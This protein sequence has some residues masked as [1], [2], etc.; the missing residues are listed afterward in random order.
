MAA[1]PRNR[2]VPGPR[3]PVTSIDVARRAGVSQSAVSRTFTPG[4]SVSEATRAKVMEAAQALGYSPNAI[5]RSLI[6]RR[7]RM[8]GVIVAYLDNQY[9]PLLLETLSQRLQREGYHTLLFFTQ[10][11]A[12]VDAVLHEILQYQVDG[13]IMFSAV[14]SSD[15]A[16]LC[17]AQGIPVVLFNRTIDD[18][19]VSSVSSDN[20]AGGRLVGRF[21][22]AGGHRRVAYVAGVEDSSTSRD[23][24]RG[25]REGLAEAG[26]ALF[27]RAVGGYTLDGAR[28]AALALFDAPERPDALFVASDHMALAVLDTLRFEL[29]LRV[30]DDV[31]VVGYDAIA[32][33]AAPSYRLTSVVQPNDAMVAEAVRLLLTR[34][35]A[36]TDPGPERVALPVRL[37]VRGSARGAPEPDLVPPE[38]V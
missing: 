29:G 37:L 14:L 20:P 19:A 5:A 13:I 12:S 34:I 15:L 3:G 38:T 26:L 35:G 24:E 21:L 33:G 6:T 10:T 2:P 31:S 30:P 17:A 27:A 11:G 16:D 8:I 36:E 23:R 1:G 18:A 22:A 7:S 28:Q 9:Y 32:L 4:A 25:L